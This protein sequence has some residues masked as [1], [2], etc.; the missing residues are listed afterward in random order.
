M[1]ERMFYGVDLFCELLFHMSE[2]MIHKIS[3]IIEVFP[4]R[5]VASRP[6]SDDELSSCLI[7]F[8][9]M[10]CELYSKRFSSL[11]EFCEVGIHF[12]G[13]IFLYE[14]TQRWRLDRI[15]GRVNDDLWRSHNED[16]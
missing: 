15:V 4:F 16:G 10:Y 7:V 8:L 6:S 11:R 1:K 3:K 2:K 13:D 12:S 9:A 14:D 5:A